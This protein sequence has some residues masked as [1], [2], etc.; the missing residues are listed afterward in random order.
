[1]FR[2][3]RLS[4]PLPSRLLQ[5]DFAEG[6]GQIKSLS[7]PLRP[8]GLQG[9]YRQSHTAGEQGSEAHSH[10]ASQQPATKSPALPSAVGSGGW[11]QAGPLWSLP[12]PSAGS[13]DLP[14]LSLLLLKSTASHFPLG[15]QGS[16]TG[17]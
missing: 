6:P 2:G 12:P 9:S 8:E 17:A 1:M 3:H 16:P 5:E 10:L 13:V 14:T 4:G 7:P 15:P 11:A